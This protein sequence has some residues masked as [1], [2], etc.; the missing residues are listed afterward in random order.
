M[1][2]KAL[3]HSNVLPLKTMVLPLYAAEGVTA[4][5][6]ILAMSIKIQNVHTSVHSEV[7]ILRTHLHVCI[8]TCRQTATVV[9]F[10]IQDWKQSLSMG[11]W[12]N[13]LYSM[14]KPRNTM[15]WAR[16]GRGGMRR[17]QYYK[18]TPTNMGNCPQCTFRWGK[19]QG[20]EQYVWSCSLRGKT[21]STCYTLCVHV[22][23]EKKSLW[24]N[25]SNS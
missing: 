12:A 25:N 10:I 4:L 9:L 11:D 15:Q 24:R 20:T 5:D 1:I 8:Y 22:R 14:S 21:R 2:F 13:K 23:R 18:F 3:S 7:F 6:S 16:G 17:K 19:K